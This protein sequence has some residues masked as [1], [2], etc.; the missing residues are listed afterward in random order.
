MHEELLSEL[1]HIGALMDPIPWY[2]VW[3]SVARDIEAGQCAKRK[4]LDLAVDLSD[5]E[6]W[7]RTLHHAGY[8]HLSYGIAPSGNYLTPRGV[9]LDLNF[10]VRHHDGSWIPAWR[11]QKSPPTPAS[12]GRII[13]IAIA[14]W[15]VPIIP[16]SAQ[17]FRESVDRR[18]ATT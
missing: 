14:G 1:A 16:S 4:D 15:Q 17:I 2:A 18:E 8:N 7:H 9:I 13:Y 3:G 12:V 5:A 6:L 11:C 10:V